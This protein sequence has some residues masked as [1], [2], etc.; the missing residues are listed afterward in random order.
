MTEGSQ[1]INDMPS[2]DR[3]REKMERLGPAA[4]SSEEL[5]A[6]FLRT[7]MAGRS[8]IEIGRGLVRKH[9]GLGP[10]GRLGVA[11]LTEEPGLG[12]AKAC[13]LMAAFELGARVARESLR[14]E[15]LDCPEVIYR[16]L[17]PITA[18]A[19]MEKLHVLVLNNRLGLIT[20]AEVSTGTVNSTLAYARD[21]LRPVLVHQGAGFILTHNHPSGDPTPSGADEVMTHLVSEAAD[22]MD[23]RF[24]DHLIVGRSLDGARPYFSFRENDKLRRKA[25]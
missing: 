19:T 7:G 21:I 1:R 22:L 15:V 3:P 18:H 14:T 25:R 20:M 10:L 6:I 17:A 4:L 13:Q 23:L 9:G 11:Q 2:D 24:L 8:A 5:L 12:P 16:Y